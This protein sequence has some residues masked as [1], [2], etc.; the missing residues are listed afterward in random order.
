V[1][2]PPEKPKLGLIVIQPTP[3]CNINCKYCYLPNRNSKATLQPET[4][5]N[6]FTR[7]FDSGWIDRT[8]TVVWHAGEPMVLPPK[9][10][11]TAFAIVRELCPPD[12]NIVQTF[13]TNGTLINDEWCELI[14]KYDVKIGVSLDGPSWVHDRSRVTRSGRGTYSRV[15][16]GI[17][18]LRNHCIDF[19][20]ISVLTRD[21]LK[22]PDA[23]FDFYVSEG[24]RCLSFNIEEIEGVNKT[25]TLRGEDVEKDFRRFM[26]RFWYLA[27]RSKHFS[28]IR[29]IEDMFSYVLRP[30]G[31][32][33]VNSQAMPF[34]ILSIDCAGNFST[35]SP[36][37][38]GLKSSVYGDFIFG[39]VN[40]D[41]LDD[42][43]AKD[44]FTRIFED[45]RRGIRICEDT[46]QYFSICGGGAPVNKL[47]ENGTIVSA[48]TMF[49]R[50]SRQVPCDLTLEL[51]ENSCDLVGTIGQRE[52]TNAPDLAKPILRSGADSKPLEA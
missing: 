33:V 7:I 36:E 45:I 3:F 32:D 22:D 2:S 11:E 23:M 31:T 1:G 4:I 15:M 8:A 39:N 52:L 34:S 43:F 35:F 19:S 14:K 26:G 42:A 6:A 44:N 50:L 9:Y 41:R 10:Y 51:I 12:V 24:I 40:N 16:A 49:C 20:V 30:Q 28:V 27:L 21:S 29:E 37:F 47:A 48:E 38:L 18:L 5:R 25:S 13:Q 46:C 17:K